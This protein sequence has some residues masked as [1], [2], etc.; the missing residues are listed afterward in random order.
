MAKKREE[1]N[2]IK[3]GKLESGSA[4]HTWPTWRKITTRRCIGPIW[5]KLLKSL[6]LVE[7]YLISPFFGDGVYLISPFFGDH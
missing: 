3:R 1:D 7:R 2:N 5:S 6:V 4:C